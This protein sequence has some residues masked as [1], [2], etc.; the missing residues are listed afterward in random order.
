MMHSY[1]LAAASGKLEQAARLQM[2][3]C[4]GSGCFQQL[5]EAL[6]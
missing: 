1:L 4:S 3:T 5:E 2:P 6:R